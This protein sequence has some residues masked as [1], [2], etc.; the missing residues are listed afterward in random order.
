MKIAMVAPR[1]LDGGGIEEHVLQISK[2]L[3]KRKHKLFIV[4][5]D[6][7]ESGQSLTLRRF[8][9]IK[10]LQVI[11][12][13]SDLK[14]LIKDYPEVHGLASKL[15]EINPDIIHIHHFNYQVNTEGLI[16]AKFLGIPFFYTPH[17]HPW[18]SWP[19]PWKSRVWKANQYT[20]HRMLLYNCDRVFAVSEQE[21]IMHIKEARIPKA[22]VVISQNGIDQNS[23]KKEM[24]WEKILNKYKI[25]HNKRYVLFFGR[26]TTERKG[27]KLSLPIFQKI[28]AAI[29]DGHFI[30]AGFYDKA[31][32]DQLMTIVIE[33]GIEK[34]ISIIGFISNIEKSTFLAK[35]DVLLAPTAYEAFGITLAEALYKKL[36][37]V[38]TNIG[39]IPYVVRNRVDGYL[40]PDQ[41]DID[42]FAKYSIRLLKDKKLAMDMG[43]S[44][45]KRVARKFNWELT[46][47]LV[48][49]R[50]RTI[51]FRKLNYR[52]NGGVTGRML[53]EKQHI[54]SSLKE[55]E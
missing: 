41:N 40:I 7:S 21:R 46:A 28:L 13:P 27:A 33:L 52:K 48:E 11:T 35:C 1:I 19:D 23:L 20:V 30:M 14:G 10:N 9:K 47:K 8:G 49:T 3:S 39:G 45:H 51:L 6:Y 32:Y 31:T 54:A 25:P 26:L 38:A 24:S 16:A 4:S 43:I 17:F 5:S 18:W 37:V 12:L 15:V 50:Y 29:P 2:F 55:N 53:L 42:S 36:P 44:G 22:K 34:N